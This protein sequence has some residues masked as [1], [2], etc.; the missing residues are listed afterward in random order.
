MLIAGNWKMNTDAV[1]GAQLA[2]DLAAAVDDADVEEVALAVCPP[3]VHLQAVGEALADSGIALGSQNVHHEESGAYTGEIAAGMLTSVGCTYA[4]VGHSERR[5]YFGETDAEIRAKIKAAIEHGL[6]PI[7]CVGETKT[8]RDAG[9]AQS[10][11]K[12]QLSGALDDISVT[13]ASNLVIAY[14]PVWAIGTGDTA[15]PEQANDMHAFIREILADRFGEAL[16]ADIHILYGGSMK[17]HNAEELLSQPD[18]DGGLVGGASLD[19]ASFIGIAQHGAQVLT[20][21]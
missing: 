11:V 18:V 4:I 16:A 13:D 7:L 10:V 1:S 2:S 3:Y 12:T 6:T 20:S 9:D 8:Q 21:K 19:A 17:P 5:E 14:E 15:T